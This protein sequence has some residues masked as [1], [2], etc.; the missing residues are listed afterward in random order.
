[1]RRVS[2]AAALALLLCFGIS[3]VAQAHVLKTDG[4]VGAVLHILPDDAPVTQTLTTYELSFRANGGGFSLK[5]CDCSTHFILNGK[6]V[7]THTLGST[8]DYYADDMVT[9]DAAG[10]YTLRVTGTPRSSAAFAPFTLDYEVR[11]GSGEAA[12]QPFPPLLWVG[13]G[14]G[15]A[16]ILLYA[17]TQEFIRKG[18]P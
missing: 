16:L 6:T 3:S 5:N 11:V 15:V 7:A 4:D 13:I 18:K 2:F 1:M 10:V 14:M 17:N 8:N 9:F 12:T